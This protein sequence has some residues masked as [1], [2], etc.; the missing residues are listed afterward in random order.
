[1]AGKDSREKLAA[2]IRE[3]YG[4]VGRLEDEY[5]DYHRHFTLDGH[6]VGSIGEV[7]A[8]ERYGLELFR[9]DWKAHD[10]KAP[11]G[12]LVQIKATQRDSVGISEKPDFL[13]VLKIDEEGGIDEVYNGPGKPVWD[14]FEGR[15]RPKNGQ[16]QISLT[17]LRKLDGKVPS[18]ERVPNLP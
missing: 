4:I 16:Y 8:A 6:L 12:R 3:L 7:Y 14:L 18:G 15:R 10:G 13:I 9:A 2:T 5:R 11:D 17:R 1:M